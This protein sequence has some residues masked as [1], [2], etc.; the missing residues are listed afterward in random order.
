MNSFLI[1]GELSGPMEKQDLLSGGDSITD[2]RENVL[3]SGVFSVF[4]KV[5][6]FGSTFF[7]V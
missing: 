2:V 7:G 3:F 1:L 6:M 4:L 5:Q